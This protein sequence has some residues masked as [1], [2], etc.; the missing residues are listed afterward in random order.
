MAALTSNKHPLSLPTEPPPIVG[1]VWVLSMTLMVPCI[2]I[3]LCF[4]V[5]DL[6]RVVRFNVPRQTRIVYTVIYALYFLL[7]VAIGFIV[8]R[9]RPFE[10]HRPLIVI[11]WIL[12]SATILEGI[13]FGVLMGKL[14][15]K[16][17]SFC[18]PNNSSTQPHHGPGN[19]ST[20]IPVDRPISCR[21][22][23]S[24]II[25]V[26]Y[27]IGPAGWLVLHVGWILMTALL[28]K[29]LRKRYADDT[30]TTSPPKCFNRFSSYHPKSSQP[31]V[32]PGFGNAGQLEEGLAMHHVDTKYT[33]SESGS[34]RGFVNRPNHYY[35]EE[36]LRRPSLGF[37]HA[38]GQFYNSVKSKLSKRG[39]FNSHKASEAPE[40]H[41]SDEEEEDDDEDV[42]NGDSDPRH[43]GSESSPSRNGKQPANSTVGKGWWLRQLEGKR[44]GEFCPCTDEDGR[45]LPEPIEG[46]WCGRPR[47]TNSLTP[48]HI[49]PSPSLQHSPIVESNHQHTEAEAGP[50]STPGTTKG[51][52]PL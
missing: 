31:P 19:N 49:S 2:A 29:A 37:L 5:A 47:V 27:T 11:Y 36:D 45:H 50:S 38:S 33:Q 8:Q 28:C 7:G 6:R 40:D 25:G 42:T 18:D 34:E 24:G 23:E 16:L 39:S 21:H 13:Y 3:I 20:M 41:S 44:R 30:F 48:S 22:G 15:G 1:G 46:C 43:Y 14:K 4:W 52:Q 9:R 32:T 51:S 17:I 10:R 12:I 35:K 26:L